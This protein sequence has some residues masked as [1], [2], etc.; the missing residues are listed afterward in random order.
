MRVPLILRIGVLVLATTGFYAYV[1]QMVPQRKFSLPG[2][3]LGA[4]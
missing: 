4:R 2:D 3:R 1:G